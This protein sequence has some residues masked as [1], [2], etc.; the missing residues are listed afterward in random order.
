[1]SI[2]ALYE[3]VGQYRQLLDMEDVPPEQLADTLAMLKGDIEEKATNL[4]FAVRN[5]QETSEAIRRAATAAIGRANAIDNRA[6]SLLDY[7][8]IQLKAAGIS[9]VEHPMLRM[10]IRTNPP[11]VIID[12]EDSIPGEFMVQPPAPPPKPDKTAI[13][14]AIKA[15]RD[16]PGAH[17]EQGERLEIKS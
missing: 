17:L 13:K 10:S 12:F 11:K 3:L 8:L 7:A 14:E 15:G 4:G 9:K 1:M 6:S 16:V 5:L 2:P